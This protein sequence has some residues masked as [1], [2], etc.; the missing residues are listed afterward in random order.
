MDKKHC[1]HPHPHLL[2]WAGR[3]AFAVGLLSSGGT[4]GAEKS[5]LAVFAP[6]AGFWLAPS[7]HSGR[8]YGPSSPGANWNIAQWGIPEDLPPFNAEGVTENRW[9][10]AKFNGRGIFLSQN[11][12][13]MPC[14]RVY[15]SGGRAVREFDLFVGP[16]KQS[17]FK[18][19]PSAA[20]DDKQRLSDVEAIRH[21]TSVTMRNFSI[22]DGACSITR[23]AVISALVLTNPPAKQTFYY[24]LRLGTQ[25]LGNVPKPGWFFTG[26]NTQAG[27]VGEFGYGDNIDQLTARDLMV[28]VGERQDYDID[29]LPRLNI[30]IANGARYGLDQNLSNWIISGSYQGL[31]NWG[32]VRVSAELD[33]Y[34]LAVVVS[35]GGLGGATPR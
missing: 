12:S 1:R 13:E 14:E 9:A 5:S 19:V 32:H 24:Q 31:I 23:V 3:L 7:D 10:A 15:P 16:N 17:L 21:R 11:S 34:A 33:D 18:G 2:L 35:L 26:N 25:G 29:L 28:R 4:Y 27:R 22:T 6:A 8:L 30:I 20:L